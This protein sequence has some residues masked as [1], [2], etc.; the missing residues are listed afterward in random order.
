MKTESP[1]KLFY[2]KFIAW[3]G[4]VNLHAD[5]ALDRVRNAV[6]P[7]TDYLPVNFSLLTVEQVNDLARD[8]WQAANYFLGIR[9]EAMRNLSSRGYDD[10]RFDRELEDRQAKEKGKA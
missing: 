9:D 8:A 10:A 4:M 6:I 1:T 2:E 3:V 7:G 5:R